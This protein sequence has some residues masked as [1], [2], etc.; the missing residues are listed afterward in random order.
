MNGYEYLVERNRLMIK[1]EDDLA[2]LKDLPDADREKA[3]KLRQAQFDIALAQL[4]S[5]MSE[6]FPGERRKKA[7]PLSDPR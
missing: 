3:I 2:T 4:Y 7:R 1:L 5:T 6:E